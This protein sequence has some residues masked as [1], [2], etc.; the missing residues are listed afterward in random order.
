MR[1]SKPLTMGVIPYESP[2]ELV[3]RVR[4]MR[5][6]RRRSRATGRCCV[7]QGTHP[8][9]GH[10]RRRTSIERR[11]GSRAVRRAWSR[12]MSTSRARSQ[13]KGHCPEP[14]QKC[15]AETDLENTTRLRSQQRLSCVFSSA[16]SRCEWR[17]RQTVRTPAWQ[18]AEQPHSA[19]Q[20]LYIAQT[21]ALTRQALPKLVGTVRGFDRCSGNAHSGR[22]GPTDLT[23]AVRT[24][25]R[26]PCDRE[27]RASCSLYWRLH[28]T[29]AQPR[30]WF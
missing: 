6:L 2:V 12:S 27:S 9:T 5:R 4:G 16:A 24:S 15:G 23:S 28:A 14:V 20:R 25:G 18:L 11:T 21:R 30:A 7:V 1:T 10:S 26:V 8:L 22:T 13:G 3:K 19:C 29:P 17:S